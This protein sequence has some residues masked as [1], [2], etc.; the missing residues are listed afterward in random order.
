MG[1]TTQIAIKMADEDWKLTTICVR[2][3]DSMVFRFFVI[4]SRYGSC[5]CRALPLPAGRLCRQIG[6]A[7]L[8]VRHSGMGAGDLVNGPKPVATRCF[9]PLPTAGRYGSVG[10]RNL[11]SMILYGHACILG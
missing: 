10:Y 4:I 8:Q 9:E 5:P 2:N 1:F 11:I 3:T 7:G 6:F